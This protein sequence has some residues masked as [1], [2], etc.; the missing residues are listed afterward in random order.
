MGIP[1][2][3]GTLE[4]HQAKE[5]VEFNDGGSAARNMKIDLRSQ[6]SLCHHTRVIWGAYRG[7]GDHVLNKGFLK[8]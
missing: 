8:S 4:R 5:G 1:D 2:R 3:C 6:P 7:I